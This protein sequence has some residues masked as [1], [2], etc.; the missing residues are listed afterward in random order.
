M[1]RFNRNARGGGG[2]KKDP[3]KDKNK[4]TLEDNYF[5]VGSSTQASD[6]EVTANFVINHIKK[7]YDY[8]KD[9]GD[10][11][12]ELKVPDIKLWVTTLQGSIV[13]D[14]VAKAIE[15]KQFEMKYKT[16]LDENV[17][18]VRALRGNLIKAYALIWEWCNKVMQNKIMTRSAFESSISDD[19]I[20]LLRA[21]KEHAL[22]FDETQYSMTVISN[23]IRTLFTTVQKEHESVADY[24]RRFKTAK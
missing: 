3:V 6:Y 16:E 21:I 17:K 22:N 23:S 11:L 2:A 9:I 15:D 8:G 19:P 5:Y 13:K 24:T 20:E 7:T 1:G 4:K 14:P 12:K 10:V 18:R